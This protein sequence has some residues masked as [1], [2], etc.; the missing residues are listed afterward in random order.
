M[1]RIKVMYNLKNNYFDIE[2]VNGGRFKIN[3]NAWNAFL[4]KNSSGTQNKRL[5]GLIT[6][7]KEK[8]NA[9]LTKGG[10]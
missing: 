9:L 6:V 3:E 2:V 4:N 5:S 10:Q 1:N 7:D 8:F